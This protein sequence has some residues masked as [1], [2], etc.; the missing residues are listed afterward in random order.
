MSRA[1]KCHGVS[2]SCSIKTCW[3]ALPDFKVIGTQ[4]KNLYANAV[5]VKRRKRNNKKIFVP[6]N[7]KIQ[8][9]SGHVLVYYTKSPD[10]CS[11]DPKSGS[12]GTHG[13]LVFILTETPNLYSLCFVLVHGHTSNKRNSPILNVWVKLDATT[14]QYPTSFSM[15]DH[16]ISSFYFDMAPR[17]RLGTIFRGILKP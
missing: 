1:C 10:Y 15:N 13:R 4:L 2:G 12:V 3:R 17:L 7:P 14:C 9:V 6:L 8:R 16:D 11:P 5:E